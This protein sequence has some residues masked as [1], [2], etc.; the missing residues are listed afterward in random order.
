[1]SKRVTILIDDDLN[2]SLRLLQA[3]QITKDHA[4]HSF[5]KVV[6][7]TLREVLDK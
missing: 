7:E 3:K 1:M 6:N 2:K 5:S 4:Y